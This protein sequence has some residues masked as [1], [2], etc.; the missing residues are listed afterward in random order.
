MSLDELRQLGLWTADC[1]E[2][3]L[4]LFEAKAPDDRRPREAIEAIRVFGAGGKRTAQLRSAALA[5]L[6]AAR[7]VEDPAASAAGRA[8]GY[9]ASSAYLHPLANPTQVRHVIAP[10]QYQALARELATGDPDD[11]DAEIRWAIEHA[12]TAVRELL[13][14]YPEGKPG[15]G[16]LGALHRQLEQGLRG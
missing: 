13:R 11:G 16:R 2:R 5:A 12:P 3:G 15:R 9:A 4:P 6:A 8:A 1:A 10:A 7:E 14:R